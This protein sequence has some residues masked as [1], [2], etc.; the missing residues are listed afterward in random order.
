MKAPPCAFSEMVG[1]IQVLTLEV[2]TAL[3]AEVLDARMRACFGAG[4]LG[5][6]LEEEPTDRLTF[7]GGGGHVSATL[8]PDGG[9]TLLR[10]VTSGWAVQVKRFVNE[11]P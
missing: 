4:G 9:G 5:L 1:K 8:R 3:S 10:I 6:N 7:T 2:R 11:L